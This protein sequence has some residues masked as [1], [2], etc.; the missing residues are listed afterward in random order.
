MLQALK[1]AWRARGHVEPNP[2]VG[3]VIVRH[4]QIVAQGYHEV[5]GQAHAERQAIADAQRKNMELSA[6]DLYV[7]LEPCCHQGKQPPCT[8]AL[9]QARPQRVIVAMQDPFPK[10][11][12]RGIA[13]LR[14][15][16]IAVEV[17]ECQEQ[18]ERLNAPF[19][20]RVATGLPWVICKWAQTL[21]GAIA[22][23]TGDSRWVSNERSR[24][25]VHRL[26]SRVDGVMVGVGTVLADDPLL[27]AR[28]VPVRR[29]ARRIVID[30]NLRTPLSSKLVT[31][32]SD[33]ALAKA[34]LLIAVSEST[35]NRDQ[36]KAESYR[37]RGAEL[38]PL[39]YLSDS[40]SAVLDIKPLLRH[41]ADR[42]Q[43]S[44]IL[45]E[46]GT[47]L[48]GHLMAQNLA[49]QVLA[50][51]APKLLGDPAARIPAHLGALHT[52]NQ[53]KPLKLVRCRRLGDDVMLD[54]QA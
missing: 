22:T 33:P 24:R 7:T 6:C 8:D 39:P 34:G 19:L 37:S 20:K 3:C 25:W 29:I 4:G 12:G 1:L 10:V 15:A 41:L 53:A 40:G 31:S 46:G 11:A 23:A 27:T 36:A 26:R 30:P 32:L 45:V 2:M 47:G 35:L 52:M 50:F 43:A 38:L 9:L 42:Y 28:D 51:V 16:G 14:Q 21:D 18:A 44:N 48:T 49:D 54:Y 5:Y 13:L 17:G